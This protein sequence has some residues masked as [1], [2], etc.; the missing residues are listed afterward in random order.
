MGIKLEHQIN[1]DFRDY[2]KAKKYLAENEY[3]ID[4]VAKKFKIES[5]NNVYYSEMKNFQIINDKGKRIQIMFKSLRDSIISKHR[6]VMVKEHPNAY[7]IWSGAYY[8]PMHKSF[9]LQKLEDV[10]ISKGDEIGLD[11]KE[12]S[13]YLTQFSLVERENLPMLL[14][15]REGWLPFKNGCLNSKTL[16]FIPHTPALFFT[17]CM[18]YKYDVSGE[19]KLKNWN[20]LL[21]LLFLGDKKVINIIEFYLGY[22]LS[23]EVSKNFQYFLL[24][25]G[26]GNNG[27]S[28]F[29]DVIRNMFTTDLYTTTMIEDMGSTNRFSS[30][31]IEGKILIINDDVSPEVFK[32][33]DF[34]KR[35]VG[36]NETLTVEKK[37]VDVYETRA[38][39][40]PIL[41]INK[42]PYLPDISKG[43]QRRFLSI[44]LELDMKDIP[45]EDL[46]KDPN[47]DKKMFIEEYPHIIKKCLNIYHSYK[48]NKELI[49]KDCLQLA[50]TRDKIVSMSSNLENWFEEKLFA[51]G[52]DKHVIKLKDLYALYK[53]H[54]EPNFK[55]QKKFANFISDLDVWATKKLKAEKIQ[56]TK[57]IG[58]L[59]KVARTTNYYIDI[60]NDEM[61]LKHKMIATSRRSVIDL[62]EVTGRS[63]GTFLVGFVY[64]TDYLIDTEEEKEIEESPF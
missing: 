29:L 33:P 5:L 59:R 18:P 7:Y 38:L 8:E 32:N 64:Q 1:F 34:L 63:M 27:K 49:E 10:V 48:D 14:K 12:V 24:L 58:L 6:M 3:P 23:Q 9:L 19:V 60:A 40:K 36:G 35:L 46:I 61:Y 21:N 16:E 57:D 54:Y 41:T 13:T 52:D 56:S 15:K 55:Y 51:T 2:L 42:P 22:I 11:N 44:P 37:G 30:S 4:F 39:A 62:L 28:F 25:I 43:F 45:K 50:K 20:K 53:Q 31:S 47:G 26:E 17:F